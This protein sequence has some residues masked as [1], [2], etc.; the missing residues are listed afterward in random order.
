MRDYKIPY[1]DWG[2][3]GE[4]YEQKL[5]SQKKGKYSVIHDSGGGKFNFRANSKFTLTI[6]SEHF[7]NSLIG[8]DDLILICVVR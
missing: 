4:G 2:R 3:G 5:R 8:R 1:V 7:V 6:S